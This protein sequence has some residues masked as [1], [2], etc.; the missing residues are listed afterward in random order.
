MPHQRKM[1]VFREII[2]QKNTLIYILDTTQKFIGDVMSIIHSTRNYDQFKLISLNRPI[3]PRKLIE[4]IQKKNMLSSHPIL[5]D[6]FLHVIDGQHRLMAA[7]ALGL[8]VYYIVDPDI[9]E[10]NI[11]L[12]QVQTPWRGRDFRRFFSGHNDHYKFYDDLCE[13]HPLLPEIFIK[14]CCAPKRDHESREFQSGHF[15][16]EFNKFTIEKNLIMVQDLFNAFVEIIDK[17]KKIETQSCY[18]IHKLVCTTGYDHKY[19]LE[20]IKTMKSE[21]IDAFSYRK[22]RDIYEKILHIYNFKREQKNKIVLDK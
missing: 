17:R 6:E 22:S 10:S 7:K 8:P 16:I 9:N 21:I 1:R 11:H 13:K 14:H 4:S 15:K 5:V 18:A 19:Y 3:N 12:C 20:K 2:R